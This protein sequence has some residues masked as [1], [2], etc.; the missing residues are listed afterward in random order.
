MS[1]RRFFSALSILLAFA[2]SA[3]VPAW[4]DSNVRIVRL[5]LVDGP[6]QLDR[7][8]GQGFE[9]AIMNM[10]IAQG[11]QL[12]TRDDSRAEIEFEEGNTIR[13]APGT[14]IEFSELVLRSDGS[15]HTVL[16]VDRGRA[17]VNY[18]RTSG[19][20]FRIRVGSRE[21]ALDRS[22]HFRLDVLDERAELA[23]FGGDLDLDSHLRVKKNNS[24]VM[25]LAGMGTYD[26]EKGINAALE[27]SWDNYRSGYHD[28]YAKSAYRGSSFYGRSDLNYYGAWMSSPYGSCWRPYGFD[29]SWDPYSSGA[30][31]YYPGYGY[32][33]VSLY[34]WGWQPYRSGAWNFVGTGFGYCWT[35]NRRYYGYGW[36]PVR[37]APVG[38]VPIHPP[39]QPPSQPPTQP[40]TIVTGGR[41]RQWQGDPPIIP[42][43]DIDVVNWRPKHDPGDRAWTFDGKHRLGGSDAPA[44]VGG[45]VSGAGAAA[46]PMAAGATAAPATRM[47]QPRRAG[48]LPDPDAGERTSRNGRNASVDGARPNHTNWNAQREQRQAQHEAQRGPRNFDRQP[49]APSHASPPPMS[50]PSHMSAPA[51]PAPARAPAAPSRGETRAN[52]PK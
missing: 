18:S 16:R 8:T 42:V 25:D 26:L 49:S 22:V 35:P 9:R 15:R 20:D 19:E 7:A 51:P 38:F 24:V 11:M 27:D 47:D 52:V 28:K 17:Y 39:V 1:T 40:P 44:V 34:P 50:A 46:T 6:V 29:A 21:I 37:N 31:A 33:W 48:R 5:S 12:W 3:S 23:V 10:P 4:T 13:L 32:T 30:W 14:K 2:L 36:A 43:G 41:G 45:S